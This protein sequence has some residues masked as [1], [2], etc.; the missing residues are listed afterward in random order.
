M[1][2]IH[3]YDAIIIGSG[4]GGTPLATALARE[5]W[6]TALVEGKHVG[7][8]CVNEG[9]TPTK[10]MVASAR[11]AYMGKRASDYGVGTG[12]VA[13]DMEKVRQEV[14][15][16]SITGL[17][18]RG[19]TDAGIE[20]L[21]GLTALQTLELGQTKVADAGL[22]HLKGLTALQTLYLGGTQV[23][24]AGVAELMRSRPSVVVHW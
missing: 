14:E 10:T 5:G 3:T 9:C 23:T 4:Q 19:A 8:T 13:V 12:K 15:A 6:R 18:L 7:G 17:R 1:A 16:H 24:N 2:K 20:H 21:K 22:E 11:A